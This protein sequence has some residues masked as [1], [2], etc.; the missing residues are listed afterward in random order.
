MLRLKSRELRRV[1][2][3]LGGELRLDL[4]AKGLALRNPPVRLRDLRGQRLPR[5]VQR[6]GQSLVV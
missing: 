1:R 5:A 2:V 3:A 4:P 6:A